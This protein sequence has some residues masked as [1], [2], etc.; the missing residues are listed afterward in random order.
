MRHQF[1]CQHSL[2]IRIDD[3][4]LNIKK[5]I[6]SKSSLKKETC[7][8]YVNEKKIKPTYKVKKGDE[9]LLLL[10]KA[11]PFC[12]F[13][14]NAEELKIKTIYE[15]DVIWV[16]NKPAK[17]KTH[18]TSFL[19]KETLF[20][21][22][23][24]R[25]NYLFNLENNLREGI[26]HRLDK[27]TSGLMVMAKNKKV[28]YDL[29]LQFKKRIVKKEYLALLKGNH[30]KGK[31]ILDFPIGVSLKNPLKRTVKKDG[32]EAITYYEVV[33]YFD[34]F[35]QIKVTPS[36]GRTH[37]IRVHFSHINHPIVGD[38]LYS[39]YY[40]KGDQL[41]LFSKCLSFKHPVAKKMMSFNLPI[42]NFF[43]E[44]IFSLKNLYEN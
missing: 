41:Y 8:L 14:N 31:G 38:A 11:R 33:K 40:K 44:M 16:V 25:K 36:T 17:I 3:Y 34:G 39:R 1:T 20:N 18:P 24:N 43:S 13:K 19:E 5:V 27:E 29:I 28:A 2:P 35:T 6:F 23:I 9:I 21:C 15:D 10:E 12:C 4:L 7:H 32:K 22:L 30:Y 42:P 37:Q 26:V